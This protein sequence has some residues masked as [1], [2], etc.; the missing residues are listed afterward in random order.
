MM[1][2]RVMVG[3]SSPD[4]VLCRV[5][6]KVIS[7]MFPF[8][9]RRP[10]SAAGWLRRPEH[11]VNIA[12]DKIPRSAIRNLRDAASL[13]SGA[14]RGQTPMLPVQDLHSRRRVH[15]CRARARQPADTILPA[16][17]FERPKAAAHG[18]LQPRHAGGALAE[19]QPARA[20]PASLVEAVQAD[21]RARRLVAAMEIA[22]PGFINLRPRPPPSRGAARGAGRGRPL[23]RADAWRQRPGC[24]SSS[25]RPTRP[26]RCT[27]ATAARRHSATRWPTC[28]HGGA[29][30]CTAS[31]TITTPACRSEAHRVGGAGARAWPQAG[32]RS[33]AR[34]AYN[35]DYIADIATDFLA[36]RT[37]S[38]P[39]MSR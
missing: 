6:L 30:P 18:D 37:V 8:L 35:G 28:W 5:G 19:D 22:G 31:S 24:W 16:V 4:Q 15:R 39:R 21:P 2:S 34:A 13:P 26:S 11:G 17:A 7:M 29:M 10:G 33:L 23:R 1:P 9:G 38:A 14:A 27:W 32:R 12:P 36:G 3:P 25:S 20:G